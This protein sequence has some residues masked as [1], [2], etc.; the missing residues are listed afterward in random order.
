MPLAL[1]ILNL[2]RLANEEAPPHSVQCE[3]TPHSAVRRAIDDHDD[4][5]IRCRAALPRG[6]LASR[7]SDGTSCARAPA[8]ASRAV[9]ASV[10][11]CGGSKE[12]IRSRQ[13]VKFSTV[14]QRGAQV[15]APG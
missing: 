11:S 1:S 3:G 9:A 12:L 8:A 13:T 2:V 5:A 10:Y 7:T 15:Y 4:D 14:R 6:Q